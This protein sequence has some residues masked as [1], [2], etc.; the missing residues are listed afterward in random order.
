MDLNQRW[1]KISDIGQEV[2]PLQAWRAVGEEL[3]IDRLSVVDIGLKLNRLAQAGKFPCLLAFCILLNGQTAGAQAKYH[4]CTSAGISQS[5][6]H[7]LLQ[8]S[9]SS[10]GE[11]RAACVCGAWPWFF[12]S[13]VWLLWKSTRGTDSPPSDPLIEMYYGYNIHENSYKLKI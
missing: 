1:V 8:L 6:H 11:Q 12:R 10:L 9:H 13:R 5:P 3:F 2:V 7:T 4:R